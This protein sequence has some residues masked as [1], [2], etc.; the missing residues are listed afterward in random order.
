MGFRLKKTENEFQ[1]TREGKFEYR[2]F[3]RGEVYEEIPPEE[4]DRFENIESSRQLA[5]G[6]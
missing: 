4:V 3:K 2:H 1:V 6:S 5:E